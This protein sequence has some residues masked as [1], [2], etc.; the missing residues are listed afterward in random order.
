MEVIVKVKLFLLSLILIP[1]LLWAAFTGIG[2]FMDMGSQ[3]IK[4]GFTIFPV[5]NEPDATADGLVFLGANNDASSDAVLNIFFEKGVET[6]S[7]AAADK[8]M[9]VRINGVYYKLMLKAY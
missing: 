1:G 7:I 9:K 3:G 8:F 4:A 5:G 6:E 2:G